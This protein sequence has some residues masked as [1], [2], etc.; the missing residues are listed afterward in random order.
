MASLGARAYMGVWGVCP[1]EVQ[2][3]TI[4]GQGLWGAKPTEAV[5]YFTGNVRVLHTYITYSV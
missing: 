4:A 1:S 3:K 5:A 2:A